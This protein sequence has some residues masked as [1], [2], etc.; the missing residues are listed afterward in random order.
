MPVWWI[1]LSSIC[2]YHIKLLRFD[3]RRPSRHGNSVRT[4]VIVNTS[5][6]QNVN[7]GNDNSFQQ[8]FSQKILNYSHGGKTQ[9]DLYTKNNRF[10]S[11][12]YLSDS[13][14]LLSLPSSFILC[15]F[16]HG[17]PIVLMLW[18]TSKAGMGGH[19]FFILILLQTSP[20]NK[21]TF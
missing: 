1:Y 9:E 11:E 20:W 18:L 16:F 8:H 5:F 12:T 19:K 13:G 10:M 2:N 14:C 17:E 21:Y 15:S 6:L 7:D 4:I 3:W